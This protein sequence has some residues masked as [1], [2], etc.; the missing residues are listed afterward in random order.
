MSYTKLPFRSAVQQ[1]GVLQGML[2]QDIS[3]SMNVG[4]SQTL[5]GKKPQTTPLEAIIKA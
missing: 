2:F 4:L 5:N 1:A 3:R